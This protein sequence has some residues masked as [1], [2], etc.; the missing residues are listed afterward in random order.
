MG[1]AVERV[2]GAVP[3]QRTCW[4]AGAALER[5]CGCEMVPFVNG[6][7]STVYGSLR[8]L[9]NGLSLSLSSLWSV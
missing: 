3:R 2:Y 8:L 1:I 4:A 5:F 7:L 6:L 9:S